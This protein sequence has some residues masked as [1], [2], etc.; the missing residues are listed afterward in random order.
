[1][2]IGELATATGTQIDTIRFYE[3]QGLLPAPG[4]TDGNFRIYRTEH[5]ERLQ[6][7]RACRALDMN[8]DDIKALLGFKDGPAGSCGGVNDLLDQHI[9]RV[10]ERMRELR[11]LER[12]L[13]AI[14]QR[15]GEERDT[16]Q[17]GILNELSLA[18]KALRLSDR[19]D[20][21]T[22][23]SIVKRPRKPPKPQ[24]GRGEVAP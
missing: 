4:R 11:D 7:I 18:S 24:D 8:L 14:R 16:S 15:C 22:A 12:D 23:P 19:H 6:F 1:M 5:V 9:A 10:Q 3:R 13:R 17:C 2:K 21:P 20:A